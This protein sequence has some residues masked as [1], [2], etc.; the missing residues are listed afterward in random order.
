MSEGS[1]KVDGVCEQTLLVAVLFGVNGDSS[2]LNSLA[3]ERVF[4]RAVYLVD[5]KFLSQKVHQLFLTV[6]VF[7]YTHN[8]MNVTT[9]LGTWSLRDEALGVEVAVFEESFHKDIYFI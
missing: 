8:W 4:V 5:D 7:S 9:F 2:A 1:N 6:Y 3:A